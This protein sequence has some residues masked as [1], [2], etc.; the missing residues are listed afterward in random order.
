MTIESAPIDQPD[1][2]AKKPSDNGVP[3]NQSIL[4]QLD[5]I[6]K[7]M[8]AHERPGHTLEP[9]ALVNE[10]W[11]RL[12][13]SVN[14]KELTRPVLVAAIVTNFRRILVDHARRRHASKRRGAGHRVTLSVVDAEAESAWSE[15]DLLALD[16][17][18]DELQH[19]YPRPRQV[20]EL[21]WFGQLPVKDIAD[22]LGISERT[23]ANDSEFAKV[24]LR[25]RMK[26]GG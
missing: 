5:V 10:A 2:A 12:A 7:R 21:R 11:I 14:L 13:S 16:E 8:L 19:A 6:A 9:H 17:A 1:P 25:S 15:V 22:L 3:L 26:S 23:V 24:W 20:I 4:Q 18:L